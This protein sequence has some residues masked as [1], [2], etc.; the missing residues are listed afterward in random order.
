MM[1]GGT[2]ILENPCIGISSN[3]YSIK[4]RKKKKKNSGSLS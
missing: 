3:K 1:N 2:P 4:H